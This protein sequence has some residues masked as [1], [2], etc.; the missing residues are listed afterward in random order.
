MKTKRKGSA[1]AN[2]GTQV[3]EGLSIDV[4]SIPQKGNGYKMKESRGE[5]IRRALIIILIGVNLG[6]WG[7]G[8][9]RRIETQ[10]ELKIGVDYFP[11]ANQHIEWNT[12]IPMI[13]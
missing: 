3:N 12:K 13:P 8:I 6:I 7:A 2:R 4:V 10:R 1:G 9:Q 5:K 11:M